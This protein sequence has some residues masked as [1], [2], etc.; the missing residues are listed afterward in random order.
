MMCIEMS[1]D[2]FADEHSLES[3]NCGSVVFGLR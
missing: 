2:R 1:L 3:R